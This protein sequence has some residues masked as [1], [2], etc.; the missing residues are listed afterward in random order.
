MKAAVYDRYGP[1]EA[2]SIRDLPRPEPKRGEVLVRVQA[3]SVT[4]ADW[5]LRAAAFPGVT[6]IPGRLMFG[7]CRPRN[8]VLGGDFAGEVVAAGAGVTRF[9]VGD[10]VFGF[11][12]LGA[13]AEFLTMAETGV[14][15]HRPDT[16]GAA[17]AAATPFG[18]LAALV[19]LRDYARLL[20]GQR[21]LVMGASGGVGTFAVQLGRRMGAQVT[22]V[23]GPASQD[24][25]RDLGAQAV[26][27]SRCDITEGPQRFDA[28]LDTAG[29]LRF[30][31]ARRILTPTGC[32]I[33]LE[34]GG[35]E[36]GQAVGARIFGGP[37]V[38]IG[39]SGDSA[40]DLEQIA[41]L[42]AQGALRPVIGARFPLARIVEAHR[43]A[44]TRHK[45]GST[46]IDVAA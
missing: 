46:V 12:G 32:F 39:V 4:S 15:A 42:L 19:F 2:V 24:L 27:Y 41:G 1:A 9:I 30:A 5:R 37:R 10:R 22:G 26:D 17:E 21:L 45:R 14:L 33:P 35:R 25:L 6:W 18:A 40:A 20:P 34:F 3:S 16:L 23:A 44:E 29:A 11:S 31:Q 43:L 13:H 36:I 28:I 7:L 8:P 38:K